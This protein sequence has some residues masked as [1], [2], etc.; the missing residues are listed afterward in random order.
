M[1]EIPPLQLAKISPLL[2]LS[3]IDSFS[4]VKPEQQPGKYTTILGIHGVG[5]NSS[6][7][8]PLIPHLPPNTR[9]LAY[10]QRSY[11]GSSSAFRS[12]AK[13]GVDA[14]AAYLEDFLAFLAW[15][16]RELGLTSKRDGG[17]VVVL[18]W[19]KGTVI[20]ISLLAL[21]DTASPSSSLNPPPPSSFLAHLAPSTSS[22]A[23]SLVESHVSSLVLF[24]PPGSAFA[25]PPTQDFLDSMS[26]VMLSPDETVTPEERALAFAGWVA[27]YRSARTDLEEAATASLERSE[28]GDL[29][30]RLVERGWER[31]CVDHGFAWS[32]AG[33]R[34]EVRKVGE[35]AIRAKLLERD[36]GRVE[37]GVAVLYGSRTVGYFEE[38]V[39]VIREWWNEDGRVG[40]GKR[41]I[42]SVE[43]TNHFGFV[44]KPREFISALMDCVEA[45]R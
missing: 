43:G 25:R 38:T 18:S 44:H 42:K 17:D 10:N 19:S 4:L 1:F 8:S 9:F 6:V 2:E 16:V 5:F 34:D 21:L 28:L 11:S 31:G 33:E 12:Q 14:T 32:L 45:T 24:E 41:A 39:E 37:V 7:F 23:D 29:D 13:G 22:L 15:S 27:G 35:A 40:E 3:Y 36:G 20:P 26:R 30:P